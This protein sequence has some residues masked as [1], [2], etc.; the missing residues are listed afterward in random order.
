MAWAEKLATGWRGRYRDQA[1][2]KR[3]V[4]QADGSLL[5]RK[6]DAIEAAEEA[7]VKARREAAK[8]AGTL[9]AHVTW[10]IGWEHDRLPEA[11][12][13]QRVYDV[14]AASVNRAVPDV[15]PAAPRGRGQL[16]TFPLPSAPPQWS[17][18]LGG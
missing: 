11:S 10:G 12:Y 8:T 7:A 9:S 5:R 18:F 2:T 14:S 13:V 16:P 4:T 1:G 17:S 3:K 15:L 6:H